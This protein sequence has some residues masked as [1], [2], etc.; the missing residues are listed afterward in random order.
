MPVESAQLWVLKDNINALASARL[1][2]DE[3]PAFTAMVDRLLRS[4]AYDEL[5]NRSD[6]ELY[7]ALLALWRALQGGHSPHISV[8]NPELGRDGWHSNRTAIQLICRDMPFVVDSVRMTLARRGLATHLLLHAPMRLRRGRDGRLLAVE[9]L[10]G[11]EAGECVT[12]VLAEIDHCADVGVRQQLADELGEVLADI[13][14]AVDDWHPMRER[15]AAVI[16]E[17]DSLPAQISREQASEAAAFLKWVMNHNFTLLGYRRYE[18][19]AV[20]GDHELRPVAASGLGLLRRAQPSPAKRLRTLPEGARREALAPRL[21]ILTKTNARARIHRPAYTDYIGIKRFNAAGE[22]VGEERFI[23]LYA[24]T[25]YHQSVLQLPLIAPKVNRVLAASGFNPGS[26]AWKALLNILESYPR[27][28]LIQAG[29]DELQRLALGIL[30][31]RDRDLTR[32]FVRR[33]L[34]GR[35]FTCLV[36]VPRERYNTRL[37]ELTQAVLARTFNSQEPVEF[38]TT[39][40]ENAFTR[41]QYRVHVADNAMEIDVA[42]LEQNLIDAA[43]GWDDKLQDALIARLGER[44][45]KTLMACYGGA[46]PPSYQEEHL[47]ALAVTDIEQL[48]QVNSEQPLGLLFYRPQEEAGDSAMVR[49]RLYQHHQPLHLSDLL[50]LLENFGLKVMGERPWRL[51]M[52]NGEQRWVLDFQMSYQGSSPLDL[53]AAQQRFQ[54]AVARVWAGELENDGFNRLVLFAGLDGDEVAVLRAYARYM[55]QIGSS[56]TPSYIEAAVA[57]H[58]D[59]ACMLH[60]LFRL[61][62]DSALSERDCSALEAQLEAALD[63]VTSLDD[64]RILRRFVE[65]IR[66]TVRTNGYRRDGGQRRPVL[67]FK[68]QPQQLSDMPQPLPLFEI[69]VYSPRVEGVHLRFGKV[70][71]GGLRWSDRREDFRTEVLGLVKAQQV[72]NT[73]IVPVG[74]KGGFVCKWP[75]AGGRDALQ[76]EG[77]ACYRLFIRGLLDLTDNIVDGALVPPPQTVRHDEDDPYLVVAADKGTASFSDIA[78]SISADYG[79]WLGDAFASGGSQGYDHKKMGITARGGWESV[80]RHFRELGIDCQTTDFTCVGIGDM[81]GDVFGNGMLMSRHIRLVGAFNHQHIFIDPN[82]DA[83]ASFAERQRLFQLPR[84][85]WS[86]YDPALISAGGGVFERSAKAIPLSPQMQQLLGVTATRLAPN[87]LIRALLRAPVD[88][89]W[90]G[91]IGTY[92]RHSRESDLDVGDRSNDAL[93]IAGNELRCRI[94][95][96]GGNLG[97]TQEGRIEYAMHGGRIN[98]DFTDNV[99]GVA[100]SD[101]EVNIKILLNRIEQ[102]GGLTRPQRDQLL[103]SM[104]DEVAALVLASC[105]DQARTI[106]V[107][108]ERGSG[109]VRELQ[110]FIQALERD[111]VLDRRLE[112]LPDDERINERLA[113]GQGFTR[114]ELAVLVAYGKMVAKRQLQLPELTD[115]PY[116]GQLLLNAFPLPLR[117]R[118]AD[119]IDRHPLRGEIIATALANLMVDEMGCNLLQRLADETGATAAE[120]GSCYLVARQLFD[121]AG[122]IRAIEQLGAS[123]DATVQYQQLQILRRVVRRAVRWLLRH[124]PRGLSIAATISRYQPAFAELAAVLDQVVDAAESAE[125]QAQIEATIGQGVPAALARQVGLLS[126]LFPALDIAE[127]A[128]QAKHSVTA[129]AR[130]YFMLGARLELHWLLAQISSQPVLNHWQAMARAASRE[131]LDWQQRSLTQAILQ[132]VATV[133]D[134]EAIYEQ[135]R[136]SHSRE[137]QRWLSLMAEFRAAQ[138]HE[139]AKFAVALRQLMLLSHNSAAS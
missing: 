67:S 98:T 80:K 31:L 115:E 74:A 82:P 38:T 4:A 14:A 121:V 15:L 106:S 128:A 6:G 73:V 99:G 131:E 7:S 43:R 44:Q 109:M 66:A 46:F 95:G 122:L 77:Q 8:I 112:R 97:F 3:A 48:E 116:C 17:L 89:L 45:A 71:R 62:F 114:P 26:H 135:W 81:A 63:Q 94:V 9:D 130:L 33:D 20:E 137:I 61:R 88:L 37:R 28:E 93:R 126:T 68:L 96:E 127:L 110:R 70:A 23:G 134:A 27:D 83:A 2:G 113:A 50:P 78:N 75:V 90:N 132:E 52:A 136:Q 65:L 64:D 40:L 104:T 138:N 54:Q 91:G 139:F 108:A 42:A 41:T 47:P 86:D 13:V 30:R 10:G 25:A 123:V 101:K 49:L 84:S 32:I 60:E 36:Y 58:A 22:V 29:E 1:G 120:V 55:R 19:V 69:F 51:T 111:G 12:L 125:L 119:D 118:F 57:R 102:A 18:L 53:P 59:I 16:G 11:D 129:I 5:R 92:V 100:C 103:A 87:E 21:L 105:R 56:F 24:A 39:F 76:A 34:Y 79:F 117:Q 107:M 35:Y 85:S 72:K 124:R 133:D